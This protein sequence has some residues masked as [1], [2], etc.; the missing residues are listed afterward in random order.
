M[1]AVALADLLYTSY[2]LAA[3]KAYEANPLMAGA[4]RAWGPTGFVAA[5]AA[6][7]AVP[8][9]IAE[10]LRSHNPRFVR[11][12]LRVALAAYLILWL[13]GIAAI[14]APR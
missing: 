8:L 7:V 4:L 9:A 6:L 3:G 12:M 13:G 10:Y 14:N 5:K 2:L 11:A 1:A